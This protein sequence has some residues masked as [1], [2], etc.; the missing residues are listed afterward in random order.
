MVALN[1]LEHAQIVQDSSVIVDEFPH[2]VSA[3]AGKDDRADVVKFTACGAPLEL[4]STVS[5]DSITVQESLLC[6]DPNCPLVVR[7]LIT[8]HS[9]RYIVNNI[10]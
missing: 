7:N 5:L 1:I 6:L 9:Y 10:R 2:T 4:N 8:N 3:F